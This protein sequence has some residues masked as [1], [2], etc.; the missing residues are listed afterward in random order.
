[1]SIEDKEYFKFTEDGAGSPA[2]RVMLGQGSS[3]TSYFAKRVDKVSSTLTYIG[4]AVP[5]TSDATAGWQISALTVTGTVTA[6]KFADGT[7]A[8]DQVW[9]DRAGLTYI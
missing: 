1:M 7:A 2:V 9:N 5:G 4:Y 6:V 8:F 3:I